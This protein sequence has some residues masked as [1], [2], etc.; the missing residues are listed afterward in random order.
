MHIPSQE[1]VI[2]SRLPDESGAGKVD[3]QSRHGQTQLFPF[4]IIP[5]FSSEP[6]QITLVNV[7]ARLPLLYK[8]AYGRYSRPS[9]S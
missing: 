3:L 8:N 9:P 2:E 5:L 6:I 7:A 1:D 4:N